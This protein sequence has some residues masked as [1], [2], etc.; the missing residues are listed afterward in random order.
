MVGNW[1][2][3]FLAAAPQVFATGDADSDEQARIAELACLVGRL[4]MDLAIAKT[5]S[6]LL[7]GMRG[8]NGGQP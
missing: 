5:A 7:D 4:T 2:Q 1:K 8:R 6:R 3:Q